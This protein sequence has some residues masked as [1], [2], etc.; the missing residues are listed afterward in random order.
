MTI[1]SCGKLNRMPLLAFTSLYFYQA[2]L[3]YSAR[4]FANTM[5]PDERFFGTASSLAHYAWFS[6]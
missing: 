1:C 4:G 5:L 6:I 2:Y 3:K